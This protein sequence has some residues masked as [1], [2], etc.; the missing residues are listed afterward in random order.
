MRKMRY[1]IAGLIVSWALFWVMAPAIPADEAEPLFA[2]VNGQPISMESYAQGLRNAGRNRFYHGTPPEDEV[3]QFRWQVGQELIDTELKLQEAGRLG[4][5]PDPQWTGPEF[6]RLVKRFS[7]DPRWEE[8]QQIVSD[9]LRLRLRRKSLL[10]QLAQRWKDAVVAPDDAQLLG[11]YR[12]NPDKFTSPGRDHVQSILLKVDPSSG[13][14]VWQQTRLLAETLKLRLDE[15]GDFAELAREFS[16]DPSAESGGD[17]GYLHQGMLGE[18]AQQAID[19]L[20]PGELT[21]VVQ[22]LEGYALFRLIDR[23]LPRV[24]PLDRVRQRATELWLRQARESVQAEQ[25]KQLRE[26]AR[27]EILDPQYRALEQELEQGQKLAEVEPGQGLNS[28][29]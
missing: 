13:Q 25:V 28:A 15:G 1:R 16:Q 2:R 19:A 9:D 8:N 12:A 17:M 21:P 7:K 6:D 22:L 18:T 27:I 11:Y 5:V 14:E 26:H 29:N 20:Q 4:L 24:N 10:S 3:R 23:E